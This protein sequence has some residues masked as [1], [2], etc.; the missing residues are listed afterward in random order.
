M[1]NFSYISNAHPAY[2][3]SLYQD[4]L[5]D[6]STVDSEWRK[7]FEGFEFATTYQTTNGTASPTTSKQTPSGID[8]NQEIQVIKLI[9]AYRY[10]GHL[11]SL[12]NP[13]RPR[14]DREA[15]LQLKDFGLTEA[16][17]E[18]EFAAA[19]VIDM[20]PAKLKDILAKLRKIYCGSLGVEYGYITDVDAYLWMRN[21][22][23]NREQEF[24]LSKEEKKHILEKLNKAVFFERF[25]HTKFV[26]QKRFSLEGGESTIPAIDAIINTA[27]ALGVEEIVIGMA[28]RGR[29]NILA[30]TLQK[31]YEQIFNEFEGSLPEDLTLGDG[32]VKYHM[33]YA[34]EVETT[35]NKKISL[36]LIPNPSHL[37]AVNPV[38]EGYVR[39]KIDGK[40]SNEHKKILPILIHG[41]AAIAG[42]GIVYEVAQMSGLEGYYTGGS[43]HFVIN[44][45]IGFT[46]DFDD[47][48]TSDYS[49]SV[50]SAIKAPVIHVNGDDVEAV[51]FAVKTAVEFRQK[52]NSDIYIDMVCY[53]KHGHNE[54]DDPNFTQ[55]TMASLIKKHA[56]PEDIYNDQLVKSRVIDQ[57]FRE[58][59]NSEFWG[60]LQQK[61]DA[62]REQPLPYKHQAPEPAWASLR[63][64]TPEDFEQS[65]PTGIE[66]T[67]ANTIVK[68]MLKIPADFNALPKIV[69]QIKKSEQAIVEENTLDWAA[70]E[71]MAYGSI[72]LEGNNVRMSG[73]DVKRGT[74]SHRHAVLR[75]YNTEK[76]YNRL[77]DLAEQQGKFFIYNSLLSEFAVLGFE[78]GYTL[79][80]PDTLTIWEAQF[81]DFANGAQTMIDQFITSSESKW[82]RMSGLV[83]L[84][85][86][87]Y[88][89]MGP[90]HSSAR[91]ERF[92]Q[93][94]AE[95]N[96][97]VANLTTPANLFHAMRRQQ[98]RPFRKPLIIMSPK[99]LLRHPKCVSSFSEVLTDTHFK[100]IIDDEFVQQPDQVRR[101]VL[102]T[103][104]VYY[105]LA[106]KQV[107][108]NIQD[109]AL[110]RIE[111]LYPLAKNQL[112]KVLAKY[113]K[114]EVVWVQ[115]EPENM[116]AW[117]YILSR[118]P[119]LGLK[120]VARK[121]SASPAT[122]YAKQHKVEQLSII[123]R[124]FENKNQN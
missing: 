55:P 10:K 65:P 18:K 47:A 93:A 9:Y 106:A 57:T 124:A 86:H 82:Q 49:T 37:E 39:A 11:L 111:Q 110:V 46:T 2:I 81:G 119:E 117:W 114:A 95:L 44:N 113:T 21:R 59:M 8:F 69:R 23:E 28:H 83:M 64:A 42:Q 13:I 103:G 90:E 12:T 63:R 116:G 51:I 89:G 6:A 73:Q 121:L 91:L 56:N 20:P 104:K 54:G 109:V 61:F 16:D 40:Y 74:F 48:R 102:C 5:K 107:D 62:V 66:E 3:E 52:F 108:E 32:D 70:A 105:Q 45:Q 29:L 92:L 84:L 87:G 35:A 115:E 118:L 94:A 112:D 100:E 77:S 75:D 36:N 34:S 14:K 4:Y 38:V 122:G 78:F 22:I 41:D 43:I 123:E 99:S 96:I 71:L 15:H 31:P 33:G 79:A 27:S 60:L 58:K 17:L 80:S 26:G 97:C 25:L 68:G 72:L 88:T 53:R 85:P 24:K 101:V 19:K 50:A 1:N 7:F 30:N 120:V 76:F 98:H 67:T